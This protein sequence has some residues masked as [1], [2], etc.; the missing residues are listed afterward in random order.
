MGWLSTNYWE[1]CYS[2]E[3]NGLYNF[4]WEVILWEEPEEMGQKLGKQILI[5]VKNFYSQ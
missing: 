3:K 1:G 5:H 2:T 4:L